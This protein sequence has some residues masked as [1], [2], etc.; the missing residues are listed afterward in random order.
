M[1]CLTFIVEARVQNRKQYAYQF[2]LRGINCASCVSSIETHLNKL[3]NVTHAQVN[4]ID[5]SLTVLTDKE[6]D[7]ANLINAIES[8]GY[9]AEYLF[10]LDQAEKEKQETFHQDYTQLILKTQFA[11][12]VGIS[13]FIVSMFNLLPAI[14]TTWGYSIN[15]LFAVAS[16]A[17]LIYSG[18]HFFKGA[19]TA[20]LN[21]SANMDTLIAIGTGIAWLYSIIVLIFLPLLPVISQHVYFEASVVIIALVNLGNLLEMRAKRHASDAIKKLM[22]LQPKTA[23]LL[24]NNQEN[25]VPIE[26]IQIND[27]IRVRPGEKIPLDGVIVEGESTV[28]ESML[29]GEP[30]AKQKQQGDK[31]TGGTFNKNGSFIFKVTHV[32]KNTV[33]AQIIQFIQQAQQSKPPLAKLTDKI[34]SYFVPAVLIIAIITALMW[35][36][37]GPQPKIVYML[38]TAMAVLIIACPCALGLAVPISVMIGIGK[39]AENGILIRDANA[40]QLAREIEIMVLD[41]TGTITKGQ[42]QVT[43]IYPANSEDKKRLLQLAASLE[44][45]SSHPLAEAI[46]TKAKEEEIHFLEVN[47]F[48]SY[49][50]QGIRG[51]IE[52]KFIYL[53]NE[54]WMQANN[55]SLDN[56]K[57]QA[58]QLASFGETPIYLAQDNKIIG[59]L[60]IAD[61]IKPDS[62]KAI[63]QLQARGLRIL[64]LTGDHKATAKAIA[65]QVGI[66]EVLAD[67]LPQDK[68]NKIMELQ[69]SGKKVG[70]VGDGINDAPAL[71]QADV[72]F[73]L[74]TGNDIAIESADIT[75]MQTSLS[76]VN[77][78]ITLS[79]LTIRNMKQ[80]LFGAFIYNVIGLP[81]AAGILYPVIGLLLNPMIAGAAMALSSLTVVTNA[82]RLRFFTMKRE[83]K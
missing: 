49:S 2:I 61:P 4:F 40:L 35:F 44:K 73:A 17:V 22:Y 57:Q 65:A 54:K 60:T 34:A 58:D 82:N 43:H 31:V 68:A 81:I 28:D 67:V 63:A 19:F 20:F 26:T 76:S 24:R 70:M 6:I 5:K 66:K 18:G 21:H 69:A 64:M 14:T 62:K 72:G 41:K 59:M 23:R 56:L 25:D 55:I 29:T 16:L 79:S 47:E 75:L 42:P 30:L 50:G 78:A 46:I 38:I 36:N 7:S 3:P 32:G 12:L 45:S 15:C 51:I 1:S 33:L 9:G 10:N 8:L 27:L 74:H 39:A 83:I 77:M 37:F 80:N 53:G 48:H 13:I 11:F 71:A 52:G